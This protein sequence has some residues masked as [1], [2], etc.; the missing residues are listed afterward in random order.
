[1]RE[2]AGKG[3]AVLMRVIAISFYQFMK[4]PDG[5]M[6][7]SVFHTLSVSRIIVL[8]FLALIGVTALLLS[9]PVASNGEPTAWVDALFTA[10][11]A[12]CV[13]GLVV[14]DTGRHWSL[15]G[16]IVIIIACQIGALGFMT[17]ITLI[18]IFIGKKITL[19]ERMLIQQTLNQGDLKGMVRLVKSVLIG[20]FLMEGVA[21]LVLSAH[22]T[23]KEKV[24]YGQGLWYG[25]FHSVCAF[26]SAGFDLFEEESLTNY[27]ND[28]AVNIIIM[29]LLI[30][31]SLG[32]TV[33]IDVITVTRNTRDKSQIFRRLSL[34]SRVVFEVTLALTIIG[35]VFFFVSE[36]DNPSTLGALP[37]SGKWLA[38]FFQSVTPRTMGFCTVGQNDLQYSSKLM[39]MVFMFIGGSPG[40]TCG[41]IKTVTFM[42]VAASVYSVIKGRD[43]I[44]LHNKKIPLSTLQKA[45]AVVGVYMLTVIGATMILTFTEESNA[46]PYELMD[47]LF[48]ALSATGTVGLSLGITPHLTV[49][50][51]LV[52][53]LCMFL[54][55]IGGITVALSISSKKTVVNTLHY[56]E[57][58][59]MVG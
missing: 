57:S 17:F 55:R 31:G 44:V 22:F 47:L 25:I 32:Y 37:L 45:L 43:S 10:V 13:T 52:M 11:S 23:V 34:Q 8:G 24:S 33:W 54:G 28:P 59:L 40:S 21:A 48:E 5:C 14:V 27:V 38:S 7:R 46:H 39:T 42:V 36:H 53:A 15:F 20:T 9:L 50:G 3:Q 49:G 41:G 26:C 18:F 4:G 1:M 19:K 2:P 35:A 30:M 56:P 58:R 12:V 16:Q 51:K 29:L 6:R